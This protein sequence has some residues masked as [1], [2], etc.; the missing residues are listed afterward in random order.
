M[1]KKGRDHLPFFYELLLHLFILQS[2]FYYGKD[3]AQ[4]TICHL[5]TK[6]NNDHLFIFNRYLR[7]GIL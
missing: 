7:S 1:V 6:H 3:V 4:R 5:D 2:L